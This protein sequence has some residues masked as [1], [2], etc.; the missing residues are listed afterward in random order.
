M[1]YKD[2]E[3]LKRAVRAI[4]SGSAVEG[5]AMEGDVLVV[6]DGPL[7]GRYRVS[8]TERLRIVPLITVTPPPKE[9]AVRAGPVP[10]WV[11]ADCSAC[12]SAFRRSRYNPY[13]DRCP[14]CRRKPVEPRP[15]DR[16][17]TC[18]K[19]G[20]NFAISKYQPYIEN[21]ERCPRCNRNEGIRRRQKR[22]RAR[23]REAGK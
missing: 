1:N 6:Y 23:A 13:M 17:F 21:P 15:G 3:E 7:S 16:P 14:S 8:G 12:G 5:S 22:R 19:C 10:E 20:Q 18:L 9:V 11:D 4:R 2:F